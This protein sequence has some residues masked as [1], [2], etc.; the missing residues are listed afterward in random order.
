MRTQKNASCETCRHKCDIHFMARE[1]NLQHEIKPIHVSFRKFEAIC[2]KN[3]PITH[4]IVMLEGT[5]KMYLEGQNKK[6]I[7]LSVLLPS[8]YIGLLALFGSNEY[9]Y[10]VSAL[11]QCYC[12]F[13]DIEFTKEIYRQSSD[14]QL[15]INKSFAA[16]MHNT[17]NKL[18]TLTQKQIRSRIAESLIYLSNLYDSDNFAPGLTRKEL[19]ELSGVSEEN[20]V[21][22]LTDFRNEGLIEVQGKTMLLLQKELLLK[23]GILG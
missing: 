18:L 21:R 19:G 16:S 2:R 20:T 14:F 6:N 23:I 15:S 4:T 22:V 13:T 9:A 1:I 12:C 7:L 3:E 10:N 8:N 5:A 11:S 17:L